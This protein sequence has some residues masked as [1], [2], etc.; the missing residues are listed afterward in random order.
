MGM[1]YEPVPLAAPAPKKPA[2]GGRAA[3]K[4]LLALLLVGLAM[5]LLADRCA[6]R[7]LPPTAPTEEAAELAVTAQEAA[8]GDG[9]PVTPSGEHSWFLGCSSFAAIFYFPFLLPRKNAFRFYFAL[10][11]RQMDGWAATAFSGELILLPVQLILGW[12]CIGRNLYSDMQ[13]KKGCLLLV[14]EISS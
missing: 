12:A 7:L 10:H 1:E 6:S 5:R 3:L 2:A 9:V 13:Q 4:L 14:T 11:Y 8:G